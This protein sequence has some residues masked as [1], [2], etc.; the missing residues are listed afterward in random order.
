MNKENRLQPE[1]FLAL[2]KS[3]RS[4]R[5]Y[6]DRPVADELVENI[7]EAGRWAPSG[8]NNQPWRFVVVRDPRVKESLSQL[9]RYAKVVRSAPVLIPVFIHKPS[10][11]HETKDHQSMGACLMNMLMMAH[12]QGLGAVWLGEILGQAEAVRQVLGLDGQFALMAVIALGWPAGGLAAGQRKSLG[13]L[14]LERL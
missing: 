2:L 11:Y 1:D 12:A 7:L 14:V 10:M 6:A 4:V 13:E 9:T 8:L 3:R 5:A